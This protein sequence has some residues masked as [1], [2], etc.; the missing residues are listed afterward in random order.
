M[1]SLTRIRSAIIHRNKDWAAV[2]RTG[3]EIEGD[4]LTRSPAGF[5]PKHQFVEDL[6]LKDLYTLTSF[7]E[8]QV[9]RADFMNR[10]LEYCRAAAPLVAFLSRAMG[11]RW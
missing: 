2:K 11:L 1:P 10:Y 9:C 3:I 7:T 6:R 5:D 4:R 8:K